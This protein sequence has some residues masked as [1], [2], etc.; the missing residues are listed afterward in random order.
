MS[1]PAFLALPDLAVD[2]VGGVALECNDELFGG[3]E[4]LV[5]ARAPKRRSDTY[6]HRGQ[7]VDGWQTRRRREPGH[8]WCV[9]RLGLP[10]VV[11]GVVIDT[12]H[13]VGD[14]PQEASLEACVIEDV[15]DRRALARASWSEIVPRS[16]L[17][18]DRANLFAV[19]TGRRF[20]HV[21]LNLFPDGGVARLRVHGEVVPNWARLRGHGG[22]I[23]LAA[24]QNGATVE[25]CSDS[26]FGAPGRLIAPSAPRGVADGWETRRRRGPGNEW[27]VIRLCAAGTI[28][29]LELDTRTFTGNAPASCVVEGIDAQLT[30]PAEVLG[31][32][33]WRPLVSCPLQPDTLHVLEPELRRIGRV[34]YLRLNL[35]P[36]GGV[37]RLRA[38]GLLDG[39]PAAGIDR[40]NRLPAVEAAAA[41]RRCCAATAWVEAMVARRPFEDQ[42]ALLRVAE[43]TFWAAGEEAWLEA[44]TAPPRAGRPGGREDRAPPWSSQAQG[45]VAIDDPALLDALAVANQAYLDRFGFLFLV[46]ATG[47]SG[48]EVLADL[49][50]RISRPRDEELRTA[51]EELLQRTR[52][53]LVRLIEELS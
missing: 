43:R 19:A 35:F 46:S 16:P 36:D 11:R 12:A 40:L 2:A 37:A 5:S 6:T 47:R 44:A 30:P 9:L 25:A 23:D 20:T 14:F 28:E 48:A 27:A 1:E 21:R 4:H 31:L 51:A 26:F 32:D 3:M 53:R 38:W 10:G 22:L 50:R 42:A 15:L 45:G 39:E 52:L 13:F 8:D 7:W 17:V 49:R 34:D 18:G 29:R 24:L 33:R 41:L